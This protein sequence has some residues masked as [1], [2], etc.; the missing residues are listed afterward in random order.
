MYMKF[1]SSFIFISVV[2]RWTEDVFFSL[3]CLK[4]YFLSDASVTLSFAFKSSGRPPNTPVRVLTEV[5]ISVV[6]FSS[7]LMQIKS[8]ST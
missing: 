1:Q 7:T 6:W 8:G 5:C 4:V 3:K 2:S